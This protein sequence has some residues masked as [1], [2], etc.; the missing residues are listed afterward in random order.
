[1]AQLRLTIPDAVS[2]DVV[3]SFAKGHGYSEM[4]ANPSVDY[5]DPD[6]SLYIT[7]PQTPRAYVVAYLEDLLLEEYTTTIARAEG[8]D[9][10]KRRRKELRQ[11]LRGE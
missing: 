1:M 7:N 8:E 6:A 4:I 2:D 9:L 10:A 3:L 5:S 11:Q